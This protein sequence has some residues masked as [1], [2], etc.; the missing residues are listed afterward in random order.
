MTVNRI[1]MKTGNSVAVY[2]RC[3][4]KEECDIDHIGCYES[5]IPGVLVRALLLDYSQRNEINVIFY[6]K[7]FLSF[8]WLFTFLP[9]IYRNARHA[10]MK[11]TATSLFRST[12]HQHSSSPVITSH[13]APPIA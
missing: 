8:Y 1:D 12:P 6:L 4:E 3:A 13:P 5:A 11:I 10:A 7:T 2:K 9:Y